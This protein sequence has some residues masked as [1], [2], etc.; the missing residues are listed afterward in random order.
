MYINCI[1][2]FEKIE[3]VCR[4]KTE[5]P[6]RRVCTNDTK[7]SFD[8]AAIYPPGQDRGNRWMMWINLCINEK[9]TGFMHHPIVEKWYVLWIKEG[10]TSKR[11]AD[12]GGFLGIL[13]E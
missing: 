9:T 13:I 2:F 12:Q 3:T 8:E 1:L 4:G 6:F 11:M 7:H 10:D 5:N